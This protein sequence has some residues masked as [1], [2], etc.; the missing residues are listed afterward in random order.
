MSRRQ[1]VMA[2]I[3]EIFEHP[4]QVK[5]HEARAFIQQERLVQQH[6]LERDQ[7]LR[8]P[9]EPEF[10]VLAPLLDAAATEL[11]LFESQVLQMVR[12]W[13]VFFIIN[14]VEPKSRTFD[15]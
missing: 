14:V 11:A 1:L 4:E 5:I 12:R 8:Q 6:L 7:M 10:L 15:F 13:R 3:E 2:G 9:L